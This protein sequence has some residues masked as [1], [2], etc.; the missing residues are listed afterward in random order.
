[1]FFPGSDQLPST[2]S[3]SLSL[4]CP[5]CGEAWSITPLNCDENDYTR[6]FVFGVKVCPNPRC[7]LMVYVIRGDGEIVD[8]LPATGN[9][10]M[11]GE[12]PEEVVSCLAEAITC[13]AN[14]SHRA[15]GLMVRRALEVLCE[16]EGV[17]DSSLRAKIQ[18]LGHC[19]DLREVALDGMRHMRV[20]GEEAATVGAPTFQD[21][22]AL[23]AALAIK[24]TK[25]LLRA[26]Y[27]YD[28]L[29]EWLRSNNTGDHVQTGPV[30]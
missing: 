29:L 24:F 23:E 1:M 22:D 6:S 3:P 18:R 28:R 21:I 4:K 15:A 25:E 5:R 17:E 14:G 10:G 13:Q 9:G 27:Q 30:G 2:H 8:A 20:L 26:R 11:G 16:V 12:I 19:V 7:K